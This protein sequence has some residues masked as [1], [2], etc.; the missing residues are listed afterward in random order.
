MS[1]VVNFLHG[2][3]TDAAGR[4]L[5]TVLGLSDAELEHRHDFIQWLF[6]LPEP[7]SAV[8]ASPVLTA[9]DIE[10]L[11]G[12][13]TA[14][15]NLAKAA[16]RMLTFYERTDRWRRPSDHNHLRITRIIKSLRLLHG[17]QAADAFHR[18]VT[19]LVDDSA[20]PVSAVSRRYWA[21]A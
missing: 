19:K 14:G 15:A 7:S 12:S 4:T 3:G 16:Q 20:A 9:A 8:P 21:A 2:M 17:D 11:K 6:P 1:P 10:A 5:E 13:P 18:H